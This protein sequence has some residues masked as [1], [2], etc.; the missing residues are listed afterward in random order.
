MPLASS[1]LFHW[2]STRKTR[3]S[4]LSGGIKVKRLLAKEASTVS[5]GPGEGVSALLAG[6]QVTVTMP[7]RR[8]KYILIGVPAV[9]ETPG[10]FSMASRGWT[11]STTRLSR[12]AVQE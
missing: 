5:P 3:F 7:G 11:V 9:T 8:E 6:Q 2:P 4:S 10:R 12:P 1:R